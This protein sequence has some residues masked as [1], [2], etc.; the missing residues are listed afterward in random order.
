MIFIS[1]PISIICPWDIGSPI[2]GF[3]KFDSPDFFAPSR[4]CGVSM[5]P[6]GLSSCAVF[7]SSGVKSEVP[8]VASTFSLL[9]WPSMFALMTSSTLRS[10]SKASNIEGV[11]VRSTILLSLFIYVKSPRRSPGDKCRSLSVALA[12]LDCASFVLIRESTTRADKII[13]DKI[14]DSTAS[15]FAQQPHSLFNISQISIEFT[16]A[17]GYLMR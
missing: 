16:V 1:L 11:I 14:R 4:L 17:I 10:F 5:D 3:D 8:I 2:L 9:A 13:P 7:G 15:I 12:V 6:C